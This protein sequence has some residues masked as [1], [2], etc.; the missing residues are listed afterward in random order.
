MTKTSRDVR[1][2]TMGVGRRKRAVLYLRVS[3]PSQV[4]TDY[5]PEG[6]SIPAQ[7]EAGQRKTAALG[8]DIVKEFIEPGKTATSIDKRPVFQEMMAWLKDHKDIDYVI[9]YHFNRIFRNSID[10][11]ITKKELAKHGARIVSTILDMGESP[12]SSMVESIIHAVDQYQSQ[13]SGADIRYKMSQK[14]KNGGTVGQAKTGYLNVRETKP[15]GGEIRTISVDPV[16][17]PLVAKAFELFGTGQ[18]SGTQVLQTVTAAGLTSR[19]TRRRPTKPLSLNTLYSMLSDRY[20]VG[21]VSY[22]GQEYKGRHEP[23]ITE[24]LF[25][26]VQ[27]VLV[28]RGGGGTRERRHNH[29]LK[30]ALWC[31]RCG[32]RC[33]IMPGKGNGGTYFYFLCRGR[34]KHAC[35]QPYIAV[36]DIEAKVEQHYATVRLTEDFRT[37][38]RQLLDDTLLYELGSMDALRKRLKGRLAELDTTEDR[39][40]ELLDDPA[41]PRAKIKQKIATI[42]VERR[43]INDQLTDTASKIDRGRE[44]FTLALKL[45]SDPQKF[46]REGGSAVRRAMNKVIF[47]KLYVDGDE[48]SG[49]DFTEGLHDLVEADRTYYRRE[50]PVSAVLADTGTARAAA[51]GWNAISPLT[52]EGLIGPKLPGRTCLTWPLRTVVQ[53]RPSWWS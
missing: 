24:E 42:E 44:F 30:G 2:A 49:Q 17:G 21:Y 27:R 38:V 7:R 19:G 10:A 9:V 4:N 31:G 18:Y 11:A 26:R 48:I 20:Y 32:S 39:Y 22:D 29:Y 37:T 46:Y 36:H 13:A 35:D 50:R 25:D 5:N 41:W 28:L 43:E 23:L 12:E 47:D 16:R 51:E 8:A 15:E 53:V 6:I 1:D 14:V 52:N 33:I 45:L 40:V 3:T 34:Q